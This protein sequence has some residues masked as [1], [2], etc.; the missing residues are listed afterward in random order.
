MEVE[1]EC[2]Y[3]GYTWTKIYYNDSIDRALPR[4]LICNDKNIKAT[5][6]NVSHTDYYAGAPPFK[7][8]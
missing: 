3:C 1:L 2:F 6:P 8:K 7:P 5:D 4:C